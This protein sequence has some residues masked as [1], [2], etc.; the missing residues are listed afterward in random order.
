MKTIFSHAKISA[1]T[2]VIPP[3]RE[4]IDDTLATR[5]E[6]DT[7]KLNRVKKSV[8]LQYRHI[9]DDSIAVSDL[10]E[11]GAN[12]LFDE[13]GLDKNTIDAIVVITQTPDFFIPAT[14]CYLHGKL[15]LPQ[16]TL[17]FDINQ[18]CAGF[19][20]GLYALFSMIENGGCKR[21][22][23]VCGDVGNK[24]NTQTTLEKNKH[25][26]QIIGDGVSVSLLEFSLDETKS[27]FE[28]G[29]DGK[30]VRYLFTPYGAFKT[31]KKEEFEGLEWINNELKE[32]YMNGLEIFNF[33]TQKEPEAFESILKYAKCTKNEL[34]YVFF[35]QANKSIVATITQRLQLDPSKT[36][37]DT[38]TKYGNLDAASIPAT[39]CDWLSTAQ[40]PLGKKLK[41]ALGGFGAGLSWANAILELDQNFWCKQTQIYKKG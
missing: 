15:D 1:M 11:Y 25:K 7:K 33:A 9:A 35:H 38:I 10:A 21:I 37:N 20:Y 26:T 32:S 12:I 39:I 22:L 28:L 18:S 6:N 4:N 27:F 24:L 13:Y 36:P 40:K 2:M 16:T 19:V 31:P 23:M 3:F 14:A 5:Y 34:D 29:N 30:G 17:A 8:G 41:I